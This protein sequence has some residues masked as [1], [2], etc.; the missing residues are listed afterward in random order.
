M[1][2]VSLIAVYLMLTVMPH[3]FV[4]ISGHRIT[5]DL[6]YTLDSSVMKWITNR[7]F[8]LKVINST[9]KRSDSPIWYQTDEIT[10]STHTGTHLDAPIHFAKN[11][12]TVAEI[13]LHHLIERPLSII[14]IVDQAQSTRDYAATVDDVK[15][16]EEINGEIPE[17]SVVI[18]R[19]GW[20]KFWPNKLDYFGT[21]TKDPKL[22]HFPGIHHDTAQWL[23]DKRKIFGLGIDSPS[24]DCG[25]CSELRTHVIVG[26]ANVYNLENIEKSIFRLPNVGATITTLPIKIAGASGTPVRVIAQYAHNHADTNSGIGLNPSILTIITFILFALYNMVHH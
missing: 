16:W 10:M 15:Q 22:A 13:P 3:F 19:T 18:F 8:E 23:V 9:S 6:S 17:E 4:E 2:L 1:A 20:S 12:W 11:R 26:N 5:V 21:D 24:V 14:D 25:Q 7:E